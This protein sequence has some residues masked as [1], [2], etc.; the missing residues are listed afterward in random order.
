VRFVVQQRLFDA[1]GSGQRDLV[2]G[3]WGGR[4]WRIGIRF[5]QQLRVEQQLGQLRI[6]R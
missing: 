1:D 3:R 6:Q 5:G 4:E 2:W